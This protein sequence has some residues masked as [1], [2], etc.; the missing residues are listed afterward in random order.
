MVC[1]LARE[2]SPTLATCGIA[3]AACPE[4]DKSR[5]CAIAAT[6]RASVRAGR[7]EFEEALDAYFSPSGTA[8]TYMTGGSRILFAT[9]ETAAGPRWLTA[10]NDAKAPWA[11]VLVMWVVGGLFLLPFPA[12]KLMVSYITWMTVVTYGLGPVV[13]LVLRRNQPMLQR[14]FRLWGAEIFAPIAFICSNWVLYRTG[15]KTDSFPFILMAVVFVLYALYYHL[16]A[17]MPPA[18]FGWRY[19]AWLLPWFGGMWILSALGDVDGGKGLLTFRPSVVAVAI[20]SLIAIE[21]ALRS[22]LP[23]AETAEMMTKMERTA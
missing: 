21:L 11:G 15:F 4:E 13:L 7:G 2:R 18:E 1:R 5:L 3:S 9:G 22:S 6:L 14:P 16:I 8:L 12:W 19:I 10:L 17:R 20:W 23:A